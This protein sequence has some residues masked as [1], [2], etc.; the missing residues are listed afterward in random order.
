MV[1]EKAIHKSGEPTPAKKKRRKARSSVNPLKPQTLKNPKAV[2]T[3][4]V[5]V[6]QSVIDGNAPLL[7]PFRQKWNYRDVIIHP[8][9]EEDFHQPTE[10]EEEQRKQMAFDWLKQQFPGTEGFADANSVKKSK[11]E[12]IEKSVKKQIRKP[13]A[14]SSSTE[15]LVVEMAKLTIKPTIS[16]DRSPTPNINSNP[17]VILLCNGMSVSSAPEILVKEKFEVIIT[18]VVSINRHK[19]LKF[20]HSHLGVFLPAKSNSHVGSQNR[21]HH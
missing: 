9:S 21:R 20:P 17:K 5:Q 11:S 10:G 6:G 19:Y 13:K 14:V 18:P 15:G 16:T 7:D 2:A 1:K 4:E 12:L 8:K 3:S